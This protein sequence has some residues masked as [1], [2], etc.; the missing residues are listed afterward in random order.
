[1]V[2]CEKCPVKGECHVCGDP[3]LKPERDCP[4]VKT[5]LIS[6]IIPQLGV[7]PCGEKIPEGTGVGT[8]KE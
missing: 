4:L 6:S 3:E 7:E 1:M 5:V 8:P 2:D